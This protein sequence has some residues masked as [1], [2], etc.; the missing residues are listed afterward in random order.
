M[1]F[2]SYLNIIYSVIEDDEVEMALAL[3]QSKSTEAGTANNT[4]TN[5]NGAPQYVG[6]DMARFKYPRLLLERIL[7]NKRKNRELEIKSTQLRKQAARMNQQ[8][9]LSTATTSS[10]TIEIS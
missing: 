6:E 5:T 4:E 1:L 10:E 9:R 3:D 8:Y 2:I 7:M